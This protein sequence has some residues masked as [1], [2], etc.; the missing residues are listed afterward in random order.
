MQI[1]GSCAAR[2][3]AAVIVLGP[4]G[5]GKSDLVF[6]LIDRG[7]ELVADDRVD[8]N[9]GWVSAPAAIAG[10]LELRGLGIVRVAHC[11]TA[12]LE[13]VVM[14]GAPERLPEP[15]MWDQAPVP[16]VSVEGHTAS[17]AQ[18]VEWALDC[19]LRQRSMVA[20]ATA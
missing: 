4:S 3:G 1:H 20:G 18:M 19:A 16:L 13:L 14:L 5:A 17:A 11:E 2:H 9:D 12:K 7:F 15:R 10:L 6:R 8:L